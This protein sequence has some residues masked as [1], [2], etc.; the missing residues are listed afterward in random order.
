MVTYHSGEPPLRTETAATETTEPV[1]RP[2][3]TVFQCRFPCD[4]Q[5]PGV[6][7]RTDQRAICFAWK[8]RSSNADGGG[9][10]KSADGH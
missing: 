8:E 7:G 5:L 6:V 3:V 10:F 1:R 9:L 4:W 2:S